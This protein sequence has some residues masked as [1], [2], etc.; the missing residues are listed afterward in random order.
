[1]SG[2]R[3]IVTG[4]VIL[5]V[6]GALFAIVG[7]RVIWWVIWRTTRSRKGPERGQ[8]GVRKVSGR[9]QEGVRKGRIHTLRASNVYSTFAIPLS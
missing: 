2:L 3:E 8:E 6:V 4:N 5:P 9:G 1:M 7:R